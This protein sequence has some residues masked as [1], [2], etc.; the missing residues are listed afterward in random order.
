MYLEE[1]KCT[2]SLY[3]NMSLNTNNNASMIDKI[4]GKI[5]R[6]C[7]SYDYVQ[8]ECSNILKN[9]RSYSTTWSDEDSEG[10]KDAQTHPMPFVESLFLTNNFPF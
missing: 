10:K 7:R 1:E 3:H 9:V 6:E 2:T 8:V 4:R 5:C